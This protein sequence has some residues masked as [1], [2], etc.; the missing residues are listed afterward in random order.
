MKTQE[1]I[2]GM[3]S[4]AKLESLVKEN[5]YKKVLLIT[6][7]RSYENS[8]AKGIIESTLADTT[9]S[10]LS[11]YLL[12]PRYEDVQT[13]LKVMQELNPHVI[14]SIGGGTVMDMGKLLAAAYSTKQDFLSIIEGKESLGK[15]LVPH[16][17]IPT[18]LGTGSEATHFA[19]V[20]VD[21]KKYSVGHPKMLPDFVILDPQLVEGLDPFQSASTG[22]DA[23]CQGIESYWSVNSTEESRGYA[24]KAIEACMRYLERVCTSPDNE[25]RE[26][27]QLAAYYSGKAIN[28]T[29]TTAAHALSYHLT[30]TYNIPHGQAVGLLIGWVFEENLKINAKNCADSRGVYFVRDCLTELMHM[31]GIQNE[32]SVAPYFNGLLDRLGL[33]TNRFIL[34]DDSKSEL[35]HTVNAERLRNNPVIIKAT[36]L[37][38]LSNFRY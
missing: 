33:Q 26:G 4:L 32:L 14:V 1:V 22:M 30:S 24:R 23:L 15:V 5:G 8:A 13:G 37:E 18:T 27:M 29:K 9:Y 38:M 11:G 35:F 12:Y 34:N 10:R 7:A 17:V 36:K 2:Q 25:S 20:Y 31:L 21:G 16:I 3:G 19:V 6:G 28:I